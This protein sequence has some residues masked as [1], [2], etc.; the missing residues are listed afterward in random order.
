M[1][2]RSRRW[3]SDRRRTN[4]SP[5]CTTSTAAAWPCCRAFDAMYQ[6]WGRMIAHQG[7]AV[8]MADFRNCVTP[9]SAP[10]IEPFPAGLNDCMS[11]L[12][13]MISN[14]DEFGINADRIVVAGESGGGNL[15]PRRRPQIG[16]GA[17]NRPDHRP[18]RDVPLHR[19]QLAARR[20]ALLDRKQRSHSR[21]AR[22][23]RRDWATAWARSTP[24]TRW[25]GR[26]LRPRK[27]CRAFPRQ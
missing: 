15:T 7:V 26:C 2:T 19:R 13:W 3:S 24:R 6:S 22:Q 20:A 14:A 9:S 16:P 12:H 21:S 11:G 18:L 1:A 23:L 25:P 27:T 4:R 5:A 10:E 8:V 17:R